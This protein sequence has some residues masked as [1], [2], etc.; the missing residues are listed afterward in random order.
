MLHIPTE[1][2]L[3]DPSFYD[4]SKY[5]LYTKHWQLMLNKHHGMKLS[6][7]LQYYLGFYL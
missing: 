5:A 4:S 6:Y 7:Q 2:Q 1:E 3:T